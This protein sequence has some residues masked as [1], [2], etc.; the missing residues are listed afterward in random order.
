MMQE[1]K[2]LSHYRESLREKIIVVAIEAFA[3]EGIKAVKMDTIAH[4]LGISKRTLYEIYDNKEDLITACIRWHQETRKRQMAQT[5]GADKN[6]I[7]IILYIYKNKVEEFHNTNPLFYSDLEKYPR[8]LEQLASDRDENA[9]SFMAFIERGVGE[10]FFRSDV[11]YHF[12]LM[13]FDAITQYIMQRHIYRRTPIE[14]IFHN[15]VLVSFRGFCTQK[16]IEALDE[17]LK[18]R[19]QIRR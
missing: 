15:L 14:D 17:S 9:R 4:R 13:L 19:S 12:V 3:N 7:D 2:T 6:V 5:I 16:G 10:G 11:D 8:V 18:E 1:T